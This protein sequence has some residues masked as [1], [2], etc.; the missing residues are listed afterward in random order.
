MSSHQPFGPFW[1][2]RG[3][4]AEWPCG[5]RKR[6]LIAEFDS[7]EVSLSLYLAGHFIAAVADLGRLPAEQVYARFMGWVR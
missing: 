3:C 1:L 2:C 6:E 4:G 5:T 7:A